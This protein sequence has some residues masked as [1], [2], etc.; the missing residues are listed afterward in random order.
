MALLFLEGYFN[1][2]SFPAHRSSKFSVSFGHT[3]KIFYT[4]VSS[5]ACILYVLLISPNLPLESQVFDTGF[6]SVI[7]VPWAYSNAL[8]PVTYFASCAH[9]NSSL[10]MQPVLTTGCHFLA[11]RYLRN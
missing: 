8:F 10:K 6:Y 5:V 4:D 9:K 11:P 1:I 3:I 7:L 2:I